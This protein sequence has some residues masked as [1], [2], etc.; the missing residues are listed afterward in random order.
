MFNSTFETS[1]FNCNLLCKIKDEKE[2]MEKN[3]TI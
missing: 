3:I 2:V 1:K